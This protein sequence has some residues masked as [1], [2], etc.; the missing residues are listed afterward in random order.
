MKELYQRV[1]IF[2]KDEGAIDEG[3]FALVLCEVKGYFFLVLSKVWGHLEEKKPFY[4]R[5]SKA[6]P[7]SLPAV[8]RAIEKNI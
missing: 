7:A 6:Q 2:N 1:S 5:T 8:G 4:W 3:F